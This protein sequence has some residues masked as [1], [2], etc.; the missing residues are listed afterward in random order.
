MN[1]EVRII[2]ID[3]YPVVRLG[4]K[5]FL[6]QFPGCTV[7]AE[8]SSDHD[9]IALAK[10][11][12]PDMIIMDLGDDQSVEV[13]QQIY[14]KMNDIHVIIFT[15]VLDE[16][17]ML[18]AIEARVRGYCLK[19][20][21]LTALTPHL[22]AIQQNYQK[23]PSPD[24]IK[25]KIKAIRAKRHAVFADLKYNELQIL[26][27]VTQGKTNKQIARHL[28][29]ATGT[30]RNY[31]SRCMKVLGLNNRTEVAALGTRYHISRYVST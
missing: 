14:N 20:A 15:D 6:S 3:K 17:L 24:E 23:W 27:L 12:K 16:R 31:V 25:A 11:C 10:K 13:A 22:R 7:V 28:S 26:A 8:G 1:N 19:Q 5:A 30:T 18:E 21:S 9:A 29:L 4:L 2:L